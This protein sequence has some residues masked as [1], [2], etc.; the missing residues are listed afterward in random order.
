MR[1]ISTMFLLFTFGLL[2]ACGSDSEFE[3]RKAEINN[4]LHSKDNKIPVAEIK[5][6]ETPKVSQYQSASLR[7]PFASRY[8]A[9]S[10]TGKSGN[11]LQSYPL[12]AL[13]IVGTIS[14][15]EQ[16]LAI[17]QTPDN[18]IF[19]VKKGDMIGDNQ[20]KVLSILPDKISIMELGSEKGKPT[21][22]RV[23]TLRMKD[24]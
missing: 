21:M 9:A 17:I 4:L 3:Q 7:S 5:K 2:S 22:Q 15:D 16:M 19:E 23:I 14:K 20:G 8:P 10:A 18:I 11:N 1:I 13:R 6:L 24:K 12:A